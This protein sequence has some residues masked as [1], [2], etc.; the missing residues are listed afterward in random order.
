LGCNIKGFVNGK[1]IDAL[2]PEL[3]PVKVAESKLIQ[4]KTRVSQVLLQ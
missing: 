4:V 1:G 3:Q 2:L